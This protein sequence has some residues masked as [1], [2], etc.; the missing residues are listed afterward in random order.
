MS[1]SDSSDSS[2]L[3]STFFSSAT[4]E[5]EMSHSQQGHLGPTG[6]PAPQREQGHPRIPGQ[7]LPT[8]SGSCGGRRAS[9][10]GSTCCGSRSTSPD[11]ADEAPDVDI[12]QGL[13]CTEHPSLRE[14][15]RGTPP[16]SLGHTAW[17][18]RGHTHATASKQLASPRPKRESH[19]SYLESLTRG[20][21]CFI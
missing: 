12:G 4:K 5:A 11:V 3:A 10:G 1:S 18:L 7:R 16:A 19:L 17:L 8:W 21:Q 9:R 2:F 15:H 6:E 20:W 13:Q 14:S